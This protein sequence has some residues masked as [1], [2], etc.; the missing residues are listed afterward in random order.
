MIIT[1]ITRNACADKLGLSAKLS[2]H[3]RSPRSCFILIRRMR[4]INAL[5]ANAK[6]EGSRSVNATGNHTDVCVCVCVDVDGAYAV[7][8]SVTRS[9]CE[10]S[11]S[12]SR[13][14]RARAYGAIIA[15]IQKT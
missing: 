3:R 11:S 10:Q 12:S 5:Q 2:N 6:T 13:D 14:A 9:V 7:W 8:V 15:W 1:I 4:T